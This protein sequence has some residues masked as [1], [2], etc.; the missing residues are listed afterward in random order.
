VYVIETGSPQ[1]KYIIDKYKDN[2]TQNI[3][4]EGPFIPIL[5]KVLLIIF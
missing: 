2:D 1:E 5:T 3:R 4:N